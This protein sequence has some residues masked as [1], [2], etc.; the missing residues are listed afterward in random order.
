MAALRGGLLISPDCCKGEMHKMSARPKYRNRHAFD[1]KIHTSK[2]IP[3]RGNW[4]LYED[5][6]QRYTAAAKTTAEYDAGVRRA[7]RES[8]V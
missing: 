1:R 4:P 5:L 8:G 6:K 3:I 2:V 7:V